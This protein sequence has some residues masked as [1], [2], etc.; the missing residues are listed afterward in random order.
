MDRPSAAAHLGS[1]GRAARQR[2]D[3]LVNNAGIYEARRRRCVRRRLARRLGADD[4]H[5]PA[6]VRPTCAG[7]PSSISATNGGGRIVN[8]ASRAAWRGDSPAHWHYA[9]SKGGDDRDDQVDRA[10]LCG[11]RHPRLRRLARLHRHRD[12]RGISARAAAAR[13]SSPK[14][15]SAASPAPT[16]SPRRSAGWRPKRRRRRPAPSS[17]STGQAMCG[18]RGLGFA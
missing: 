1:R 2:I 18:E 17:T 16:K 3:A 4:A 11:R 13:R 7:W 8:V 9:A 15:R 10:R 6:G 5:Q 14:S 12:D